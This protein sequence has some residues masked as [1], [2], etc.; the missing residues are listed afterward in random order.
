[1]IGQVLTMA[2]IEVTKQQ[3]VE[4]WTLSNEARRNALSLDVV[5][6]LSACLDRVR[7]DRSVRAVV[8]TGAGSAAFC[9]GADLKERA[10]MSA[11]QVTAFLSL[12][13]NTLNAFAACDTIFIAYLNGSA[14]G[15]GLE[16]ALCCDLRLASDTAQMGLTEVS[17]GIIPGA[18]GTQRLP[19]VV[20]SSVAKDLI[21]TGRRVDAAEALRLGLVSRVC[22]FDSAKET[23]MQIAANAPLALGAAKQAIDR[24]YDLT[25]SEGLQLE[26]SMYARTLHSEDRLEG[27]RAFAEKRPPRFT[28]R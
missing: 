9:A 4:I 8:L 15:G 28:G 22:S 2:S 26:Q 12:L 16:L 5:N 13:Q 1:M 18:G 27:L 25:L 3:S 6:S 17:L 14:F 11:E 21:L 10:N 20:G 7:V 24:G 23:A 19:R